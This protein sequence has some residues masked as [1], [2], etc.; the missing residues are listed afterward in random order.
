[1]S[2]SAYRK[3]RNLTRREIGD[4]IG[5]SAEFIRLCERGDRRLAPEKAILLEEKTGGGL[6]KHIT[7][8]DLWEEAAA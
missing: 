2:I 7:R 6:P 4:L 8:P 3:T 5:V 1:M